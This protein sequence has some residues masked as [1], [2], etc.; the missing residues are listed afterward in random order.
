M[1]A[2]GR[3]Q[4]HKPSPEGKGYIPSIGVD[5][6]FMGQD[7]GQ[8]F[9]ILI[10]KD[11]HTLTYGATALDTKGVADYS[12]ASSWVGCVAWDTSVSCG[13]ATTSRRSWRCG[14]L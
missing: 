4:A 14:R 2:R 8:R 9:P 11:S 13:A 3:G 1:A 10:M 6:G 12:V 5:F 7:G